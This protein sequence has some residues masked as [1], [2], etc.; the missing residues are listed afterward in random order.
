MCNWLANESVLIAGML[1][2]IP[3]LCGYPMGELQSLPMLGGV[4]CGTKLGA[5]D[6]GCRILNPKGSCDISSGRARPRGGDRWKKIRD[7]RNGLE[8][9]WTT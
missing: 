6:R 5:E 7:E 8:R 4:A 3:G 2:C 9:W 1:T